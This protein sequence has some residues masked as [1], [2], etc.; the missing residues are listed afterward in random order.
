VRVPPP[1]PNGFTLIEALVV[2]AVVGMVAGLAFPAME[3][4]R[5]A[6]GVRHAR[7]QALAALAD[8]RTRAVRTGTQAAVSAMA[9][10]TAVGINDRPAYPLGSDGDARIE[11]APARIVFYA[12][13]SATGGELRITA[14]GART[15]LTVASDT[16]LVSVD[17]G[18]G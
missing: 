3:R 11:A 18:N 10:G 8:A 13:G 9:G 4:A 2:L 1:R 5:T 17:A 16:G 12:D 6:L 15:I 14:A 7:E